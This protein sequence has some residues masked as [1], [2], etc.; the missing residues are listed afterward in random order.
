MEPKLW[1]VAG[2]QSLHN[3]LND[4]RWYRRLTDTDYAD[5]IRSGPGAILPDHPDHGIRCF[6]VYVLPGDCH[7]AGQPV[8]TPRG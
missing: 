6:R 5:P 3:H 8:V 1:P 4:H 2:D 7:I